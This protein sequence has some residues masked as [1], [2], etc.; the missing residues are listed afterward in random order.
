[1]KFKHLLILP[2]LGPLAFSID[3][4]KEY[5]ESLEMEGLPLVKAV[6]QINKIHSNKSEGRSEFKILIDDPLN[7]NDPVS[8]SL[9]NVNLDLLMRLLLTGTGYHY[10][11]SG[12]FIVIQNSKSEFDNNVSAEDINTRD[13][14]C[15]IEVNQ[16]VAE[17]LGSMGFGGHGSGFLCE[18]NGAKFLITNIHVIE[19]ANSLSDISVKTRDNIEVN[20]TQGYIAQ[21]RD[22]CIFRHEEDSRLKYLEV[23]ENIPNIQSNAPIYLLG[24]PLGGNVMRKADGTLKGIGPYELEVNCSAFPGNSGGPIISA[25]SGKVIGLLTKGARVPNDT[26]TDLAREKLGNPFK[27]DLRVF[28]TR[29]DTVTGESWIQI[30]WSIWKNHKLRL[31][32]HR[33]SLLALDS[34]VSSNY[35]PGTL[36]ANEDSLIRDADL[37]R[38]YKICAYDYSE[39]IKANNPTAVKSALQSFISYIEISYRPITGSRWMELEKP[40]KY[41]WFVSS[42]SGNEGVFLL[43]D[44]IQKMYHILHNEW[45]IMQQRWKLD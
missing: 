8:L 28:G 17:E 35:K 27:D 26:F 22:L 19:G 39:A 41:E 43:R 21:D 16:S 1:M 32:K 18:F 30:N 10:I 20:L 15:K 23:S 44:N 42:K 4:Q 40:I 6:D 34:L 7:M 36:I 3:M 9:N 5:F 13:S 29:I 31:N 2:L 14:V 45:L 33:N 38:W 11:F 12:N 25:T 37:W 24:Y